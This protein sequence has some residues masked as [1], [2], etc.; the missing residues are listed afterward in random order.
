M[1]ASVVSSSGEV[2]AQLN[3]TSGQLSVTAGGQTKTLGTTYAS[4]DELFINMT[5]DL[6]ND[7]F[8][9]NLDNSS[10]TASQSNAVT[11]TSNAAV[12]FAKLR[13][14]Y[15]PAI[16]EAIPGTSVADTITIRWRS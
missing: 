12:D 15:P 3:A 2:L 16:V 7:T 9:V 5:F 4:G 10:G 14:A 6:D 8:V 13:L 1:S 11:V